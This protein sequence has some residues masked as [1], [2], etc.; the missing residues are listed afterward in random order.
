MIFLGKIVKVRGNKGEVVIASSPMLEVY[1]PQIG[2][3]LI[4]KSKKYQKQFTVESVKDLRGS[5]VI[6]FQ[7]IKTMNDAFKLI[8]YSAYS[9]AEQEVQDDEPVIQFTVKD[10]Q[11]VVWGIVKDIETAGLSEIMEIEDPQGDN[12][13]VPFCEPIV[14]SIDPQLKLIVIDPPDGLKDLNKD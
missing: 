3:V 14:T 2:E 1:T 11:G 13:Y 5:C 4:L 12:I 9:E 7:E 10:L 6:K 8:T